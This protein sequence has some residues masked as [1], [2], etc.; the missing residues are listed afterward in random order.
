M[1]Q[2]E[3]IV[4]TKTHTQEYVFIYLNVSL[5]VVPESVLV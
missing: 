4:C 1:I 3:R 5:N 2:A